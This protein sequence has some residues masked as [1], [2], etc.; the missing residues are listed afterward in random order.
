M[1]IVDIGF[2]SLNFESENLIIRFFDVNIT[3]NKSDL[4]QYQNNGITCNVNYTI[5]IGNIQILLKK[6]L[7]SSK[8]VAFTA[9]IIFPNNNIDVRLFI[10][11]IQNCINI[12]SS[13]DFLDVL[14]DTVILPALGNRQQITLRNITTADEII[15]TISY[16]NNKLNIIL[17]VNGTI[18]NQ[19][20]TFTVGI[21]PKQYISLFVESF[22]VNSL[23]DVLDGLSFSNI[24]LII[25]P[26]KILL[27]KQY[28][29]GIHLSGEINISPSHDAILDIP[30]LFLS[31]N[32]QVQIDIEKQ[33]QFKFYIS[34][35][36]YTE[37]FSISDIIKYEIGQ[38]S[39]LIQNFNTISLSLGGRL[40][41]K[42][43]PR[44]DGSVSDLIIHAML[45][46][47]I[48]RTNLSASIRLIDPIDITN[49]VILET[50]QFNISS[51]STSG[52]TSPLSLLRLCI[53]DT[54]EIIGTITAWNS[55]AYG[56]AIISKN[57]I[58]FQTR[59]ENP[60]DII[61]N[62]CGNPT[63]DIFKLLKIIQV[64]YIE[65]EGSTATFPGYTKGIK[66]EGAIGAVPPIEEYKT[67]NDI[68]RGVYVLQNLL[69]NDI[70]LRDLIIKFLYDANTP[71]NS[72]ISVAIDLGLQFTIANI[73]TELDSLGLE[74][75]ANPSIGFFSRIYLQPPNSDRLTFSLFLRFNTQTLTLEAS[76]LGIWNN[77]FGIRGV[78]I[79]NLG[80]RVDKAYSDIAN[81]PALLVPG[82]NIGALVKALLPSG[83][84]FAGEIQIQDPEYL[85]EDPLILQIQSII[86]QKVDDIGFFGYLNTG[87]YNSIAVI[88]NK[89]T[90]LFLQGQQLPSDLY[91]ALDQIRLNIL[92][93][94]FVPTG[95]K[96]GDITIEQ[97]FGF[98]IDAYFL[99]RFNLIGKF[100]I[101]KGF[102]FKGELPR[103]NIP[104]ILQFYGT[105]LGSEGKLIEDPSKNPTI[106][107][108]VNLQSILQSSIKAN[109]YLRLFDAISLATNFNISKSGLIVQ[110]LLES[111]TARIN[112]NINIKSELSI[113]A[114]IEI[115]NPAGLIIDAV[116]LLTDTISQ[117]ITEGL[118][119]T[120]NT[121]IEFINNSESIYNDNLPY[122]NSLTP[123]LCDQFISDIESEI[124][125]NIENGLTF[126]L[127][128]VEDYRNKEQIYNDK[129]AIREQNRNM[130]RQTLQSNNIQ[131]DPDNIEQILSIQQKRLDEQRRLRENKEYM[132]EY[133]IA[134]IRSSFNCERFSAWYEFAVRIGCEVL[135]ETAVNAINT[136]SIF[137]NEILV[138]AYDLIISIVNKINELINLI[139]N[140]LLVVRNIWN[141]VVNAVNIALQN[142]QS[143]N[144]NNLVQRGFEL[145]NRISSEIIKWFKYS[146]IRASASITPITILQFEQIQGPALIFLDSILPILNNL[147]SLRINIPFTLEISNVLTQVRNSL[148]PRTST[149]QGLPYNLPQDFKNI[150]LEF[151][152]IFAMVQDPFVNVPII[153]NY[154]FAQLL[155][156][157]A[158][159]NY[160][161]IYEI[162]N[163]PT[164][165]AITELNSYDTIV[166]AGVTIPTISSIVRFIQEQINI[167]N[168]RM[169]G[170]ITKTQF[171]IQI[172][173][174][175][176][177]TLFG[178][179][180]VV[181]PTIIDV[182]NLIISILTFIYNT[183]ADRFLKK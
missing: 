71:R 69:Y 179:T 24:Y 17:Q 154:F 109:A 90:K 166:V 6:L 51:T 68:E 125:S 19:R 114:D 39:L 107:I 126:V 91:D 16:V 14:S 35:L 12:I 165:K 147:R 142:L 10:N 111:G 82:V 89:T 7:L 3:I 152:Q 85:N 48:S 182:R 87:T 99:D 66:F 41:I 146:L 110:T 171:T 78:S 15:G 123:E 180:Y 174:P 134:N 21:V 80:I 149:V 101:G 178:R 45:T 50:L 148:N 88:T 81:I 163:S 20:S 29:P 42:D 106:E 9:A 60:L 130:L 95:A 28:N 169:I 46:I 58:G 75:T 177:I 5:S 117:K 74:V 1:S 40:T 8:G 127:T 96:V 135:R 64:K 67:G 55:K 155:K 141:S 102:Y 23:I 167:E 128:G 37:L 115:S 139:N 144:L 94:K 31:Q 137:S 151:K 116:E 124:Y 131:S 162:R 49:D 140:V 57:G 86:S 43:V 13:T 97:G 32:T 108:D 138:W 63:D 30:Y 84:G 38:C 121:I 33:R 44:L 136:A 112:T 54:M 56:R 61:D 156:P 159:I 120:N 4:S 2:F 143:I 36:G 183:I 181:Q 122:Y 113:E 62:I 168:F 22:D 93:L 129:V 25:N 133:A 118:T 170:V 153:F 52:I 100:E 104:G 76:L 73:Q 92:S 70:I 105:K 160:I 158:N 11:P 98:E 132:R 161:G 157:L 77:I 176:T 79:G 145:V 175:F 119:N 34:R 53:P 172:V 65:L 27:D 26:Q 59:I 103:I 18:F 164:I 173:N 83:I 72:S 150:Q 47:S